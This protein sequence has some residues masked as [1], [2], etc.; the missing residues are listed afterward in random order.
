[1]TANSD[2]YSLAAILFAG[3]LV[4]GCASAP[5]PKPVQVAPP[6]PAAR[7]LA[8]SIVLVDADGSDVDLAAPWGTG[9]AWT[10]VMAGVAVQGHHVVVGG[11]GLRNAAHVRVQKPG[12]GEKVPAKVV[13]F[14]GCGLA[15]LSVDDAGFWNGVPAA[16]ISGVTQTSSVAQLFHAAHD[17]AHLDSA[18]VSFVGTRV[19]GMCDLV[20]LKIGQ[21]EQKQI[22]P[23]DILGSP[24]ELQGIVMSTGGS[25]GPVAFTPRL[26]ADFVAEASKPQY[27]GYATLGAQWQ[28]L[29]SPALREELGLKADDGGVRITAVHSISSAQGA[30]QPGDVLL[31]LE[32]LKVDTDGTCETPELGRVPFYGLISDGHH[33]GDVLTLGILRA[34]ARSTVKI[35]LKPWSDDADLIPWSAPEE[36]PT[37][38]L[39][40]GGLLFETLSVNYLEA[41]GQDWESKAP[42][43]LLEAYSL[44]RFDPSPDRP[45][46]IILSRVLADPATLGYGTLRD[47]I[48][49]TVNG[50]HVRS[51]DDVRA[52]FA[53]PQNGFDV[54]TFTAGQ[55]VRRIVLDAE[56]ARAATERFAATYGAPKAS[57]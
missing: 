17:S 5:A 36:T 19:Q 22:A 11:W 49:D 38:F 48:V 28:T 14:D 29:R 6:P 56:E 21:S 41:A 51:L 53:K 26:V 23:S 4:A 25:A 35:T 47:L 27:R 55:Y 13:R 40:A 52:A 31:T 43:P 33:P 10:R 50:A 9:K 44:D 34:G 2:R 12:S 20:T 42:L 18:S 3:A 39:V 24:T 7:A 54:V 15:L 46:V 16:L 8:D 37:R 32:G 45:R 30:L 57:E 1:M